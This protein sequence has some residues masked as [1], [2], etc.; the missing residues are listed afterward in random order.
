MAVL[1]VEDE[2]YVKVEKFAKQEDRNRE[3][4]TSEAITLLKS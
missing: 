1:T 3:E 2:V 4:V